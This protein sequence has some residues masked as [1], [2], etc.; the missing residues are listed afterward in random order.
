MTENDIDRTRR[1]AASMV[2]ALYPRKR[3]APPPV[4]RECLSSKVSRHHVMAGADS[5]GQAT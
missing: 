1:R 3:E 4:W 2:L 5:E